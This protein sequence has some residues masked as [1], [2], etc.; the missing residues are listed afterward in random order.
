MLFFGGGGGGGG[1]EK[2]LIS[3]LPLK[4]SIIIT[5]FFHNQMCFRGGDYLGNLYAAFGIDVLLAKSWVIQIAGSKRHDLGR[6]AHGLYT[7]PC[8]VLETFHYSRGQA[9]HQEPDYRNV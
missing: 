2:E 8:F 3:R 7:L 9:W 6:T 5:F 4:L 1:G